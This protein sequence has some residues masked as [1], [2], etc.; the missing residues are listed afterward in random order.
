MNREDAARH[1]A[2]ELK[3]FKQAR[4]LILA[5]PRGAVP[6]GRVIADLLDADLDVAL[7]HK[8]GAPHNP[9]YAIGAVSEFGDILLSDASTFFDEPYIA[10]QAQQEIDKLRRKRREYTPIRPPQDPKGR[11]VILV[12]DGIATGSTMLNAIRTARKQG[13]S[14]VIVASPVAAAVVRDRLAREAD[15]VILLETPQ[16]FGAVSAFYDD[17]RQVSDADVREA[18]QDTGKPRAA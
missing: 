3:R 17:F 11:L 5:I 8:I 1:L 10:S 14:R 9:E 12:D 6:M 18:L 7:V 2:A 4:P 15:E 13:A 16:D